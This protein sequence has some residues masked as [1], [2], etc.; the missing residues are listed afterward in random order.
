MKVRI[1]ASVEVISRFDDSKTVL[2]QF[3]TA[4]FWAVNATVATRYKNARN[5]AITPV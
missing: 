5:I 1:S 3:C 4:V 2:G